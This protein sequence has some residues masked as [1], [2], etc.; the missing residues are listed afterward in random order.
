MKRLQ[1]KNLLANSRILGNLKGVK[2]SY[3][4]TKNINKLKEE[5]TALDE[6]IK[7]TDAFNEFQKQ[8]IAL[9][10]KHAKLD[11]NG[12]P[13]VIKEKDENGRPVERYDIVNQKLFETDLETLRVE[14][15]DALDEMENKI[16]E[17]NELMK[18]D[19]EVELHEIKLSDVPEDITAQQ[20]S[21]IS[22]LIVE[23]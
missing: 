5:F 17:Y 2:F 20:M 8:R 21:I 23:D 12:R 18:T 19:V 14:H 10:E 16:K 9:A 13:V 4:I 3:M 22:D 1:A 6:A 15:K 11:E 7:T